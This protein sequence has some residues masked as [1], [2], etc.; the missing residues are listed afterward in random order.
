MSEVLNKRNCPVCGSPVVLRN[1][2]IDALHPSR[3]LAGGSA[4][5]TCIGCGAEFSAEF[6]GLHLKRDVSFEIDE[7]SVGVLGEIRPPRIY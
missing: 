5:W 6:D 7:P 4:S 2:S 3:R 1:A